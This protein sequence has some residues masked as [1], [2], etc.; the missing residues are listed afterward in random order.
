MLP[1]EERLHKAKAPTGEKD[2]ILEL[3]C[4]WPW[5]DEAHRAVTRSGNQDMHHRAYLCASPTFCGNPPVHV[6]SYR[7]VLAL[8]DRGYAVSR[9]RSYDKNPYSITYAERPAEHCP[10]GAFGERKGHKDAQNTPEG[11][12]KWAKIDVPERDNA[13]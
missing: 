9:M 7:Q 10:P 11:S 6:R 12:Q 13:K 8:Q 1:T 5:R 3:P 2:R 4:T